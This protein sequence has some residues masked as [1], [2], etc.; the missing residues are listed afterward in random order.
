MLLD[1]YAGSVRLALAAYNA[2]IK[3]VEEVNDFVAAQLVAW[4]EKRNPEF[5]AA[6]RGD[7]YRRYGELQAHRAADVLHIRFD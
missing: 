2:G 6:W 4:L 3:A 5:C 7:F 1:R